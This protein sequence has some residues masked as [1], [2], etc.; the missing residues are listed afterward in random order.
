MSDLNRK[1][2]RRFY[3]LA[4]NQGKLE[5]VD[6]VLA[7]DCIVHD[8]A[9]PD[10]AVL[11]DAETPQLLAEAERMARSPTLSNYLKFHAVRRELSRSAASMQLGNLEK[12]NRAVRGLLVARFIEWF[13]GDN[14]AV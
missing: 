4:Y 13:E 5:V 8:P 1:Q 14:R 6:E 7:P 12:K 3:D 10:F 11:L 9:K 2:A